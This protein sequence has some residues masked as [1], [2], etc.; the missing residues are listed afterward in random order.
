MQVIAGQLSG[1]LFNTESARMVE[2]ETQARANGQPVHGDSS[3]AA[4]KGSARDAALRA[5][6]ASRTLQALPTKVRSARHQSS[7]PS[8]ASTAS[9]AARCAVHAG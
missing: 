6:D 3:A 1:T 2:L 4:A 5:R 8:K 9:G 7:S